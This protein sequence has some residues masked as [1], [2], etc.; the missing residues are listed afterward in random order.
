MSATRL[1]Y[2]TASRGGLHHALILHGPDPNRL[3]DVAIGIAKALQCPEGSL[4]D[5]CPTCS[6]I[7]RGAHP[8]VKTIAVAEQ[9]KLIAIE[10]IRGMIAEATLR[11]YEGKHK[12]FIVD[13]A[14]AMSV[15]GA[16][17]LLKTLEEPV[18]N[19]IFLLL[20]RSADLL[21][22]TIRSR[23]QSIPIRPDVEIP[24][25]ELARTEGLPLQ[26]A[27]LQQLLPGVDLETIREATGSIVHAV[28]AY[29]TEDDT[30]ALLALSAELSAIGEPR[31]A[32]T[33]LAAALRDLAALE[34]DHSVD[35]AAV[36]RVRKGIDVARLLEASEAALRGF[37]K[38][39]VNA[40]IRLV[41]DQI[42]I[43]LTKK[44]P[45][46]FGRG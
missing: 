29:A 19:S 13:P 40:D 18:G 44:P 42:L 34:S 11:P 27:R 23:S 30:A 5:S 12:V 2:K 9:R 21:L 15:S 1:L 24:A 31:V 25:R 8:D 38:M 26:I 4:G 45:R 7:D 10:Q 39:I 14:D 16:N 28:E 35:P 6:R 46:P 3:R 22:P 20:T 41:L 43:Q 32:L 17:A 37:A 36:E 33:I